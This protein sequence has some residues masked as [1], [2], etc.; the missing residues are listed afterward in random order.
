M[1]VKK[2]IK[3]LEEKIA[4]VEKIYNNLYEENEGARVLLDEF[5][6]KHYIVHRGAW[7]TNDAENHYLSELD[8]IAKRDE[9]CK[10]YIEESQD[11]LKKVIWLNEELEAND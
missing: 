3:K 2:I 7:D 8:V 6:A 5:R 9:V 4:K 10:N 11:W 1:K